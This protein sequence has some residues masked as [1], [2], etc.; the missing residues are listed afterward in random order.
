LRRRLAFVFSRRIEIEYTVLDAWNPYFR[1][2]NPGLFK[3]IYYV[4]FNMRRG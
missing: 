2:Q 1:G 3:Y 4:V